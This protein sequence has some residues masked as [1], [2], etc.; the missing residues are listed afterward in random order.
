MT[1]TDIMIAEPVF[2]KKTMKQI[3]VIQVQNYRNYMFKTKY[4]SCIKAS[5]DKLTQKVFH[6]AVIG[7]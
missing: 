7:Y 1:V 6:E 3:I 5:Q 4:L 2:Y